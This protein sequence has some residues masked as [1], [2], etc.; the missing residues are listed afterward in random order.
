MIEVE[1]PG[2]KDALVA[3]ERANAQLG[4]NVKVK[5]A[6]RVAAVRGAGEPVTLQA[7][8]DDVVEL[9]MDGGAVLWIRADELKDQLGGAAARGADGKV[10]I[11]DPTI[12]LD[13]GT[14]GLGAWAIEG[15]QVLGI[16]LAGRTAREIAEAY[17]AKVVPQPGL[18][19]WNGSGL[20]AIEAKEAGGKPWLLFLHGTASNSQAGFGDLPNLQPGIWST[21]RASYGER[22]LAF[23]HRTLTLSPIANALDL[24]SALP[25]GA[26]LHLVSHSRGGLVGEL[27]GRGQ[28][29]DDAGQ[30]RPPFDETDLK[31]FAEE[32]FAGQRQELANLNEALAR[33]QIK[34]TRFVRVACPA[35][36]TS[37]TGGR[38][39][40]WL[41]LV[42]DVA[43]L[44][45]GGRLNPVTSELLDALRALVQAV[46]KERTDPTTL[47][48]LAA[49]SPEFSPLL[50]VLNRKDVRQ[51]DGLQ[52]IAGDIDPTEILHRLAVWFTDLYFGRD[53]DLVVD[54]GS[55]D[56]GAPRVKPPQLF[57]D[58]GAAVNHF[59]YFANPSSAQV[60]GK[61]LSSTVAK[62]ELGA[63]LSRAAQTAMPAL[64]SRGVGQ[65]PIVLV[66]PG[67][68]GSHL[69]IGQRRIWIDILQLA[70]GGIAR[71]GIGNAQIEPDEPVG[72]YYGELCRFLDAT[73]EVR[74]WAYDWRRSILEIATG[75]ARD[76]HQALDAT[77][78]PV[79]VIAHSMGGLV[80]RTAFAQDSSL[81]QRFKD[82][83]GSRLVMLGTPNGGS[84]SIPMLL[85]GRNRLMQYLGLLDLTA[86]S[87]DLLRVVV[88]WS[89]ALQMLPA[90]RAD[91]LEIAGWTELEQDDPGLG[92]TLP[93]AA[94]LAEV[95]QF[96]EVFD[97]APADPLRMFYI[98]GQA[99]TYDGIRVDKRA[100]AGQRIAFT[101]T[102][103]GDGQV[104]WKTGIPEGIR[105]WYTLAAHGDLARHEPAFAAIL[106]LLQRGTTDR[107]PTRLPV[108]ARS[109]G[110]PEAVTREVAPVVPSEEQL[111]AAAIGSSVVPTAAATR[112]EIAV[113]V[114]HGHLAFASHPVLVG[115]YLGDSLNGTEAVLD[116]RQYGRISARRKL[117][118]HPG[119]IE[120]FDVYL[121][122]RTDPKPHPPGSVIVGLGEISELTSG[123]LQR[124][125]RRGVLALAAAID[126][127]D[128]ALR[129][130]KG[131]A[132]AAPEPRGVSCI[133]IGTGEGVIAVS[134]C[135]MAIMRAV[136]QANRL[137]GKG[138]FEQLEII[139]VVEQQAINAWHAVNQRLERAEFKRRFALQ[140]ELRRTKGAERRIG[141]EADPSWWTPVTITSVRE[142]GGD[143]T[144]A[145]SQADSGTLKYV[146]IA[147][148][149]RAEASL[150]AT[151]R[152]FVDRYVSRMTRRR[153][154]AGPVSAPRTLFELLWPNRL[155]DQSLDDRNIRLILDESSAALPWEM[156][157]DRRPW[158]ADGDDDSE[159][160][161]T[162]GPPATRH[163]I[164]RQLIS[165]RFRE[166]LASPG[167]R[168]K[169]LVIGDPRGE[170]SPLQELPGAQREAEA[171]RQLLE[172]R[173]YKVTPLIGAKAKPEH[174]VSA[175]FADAWE[176]V[177]VAAHGVVKYVFP[178]EMLAATRA[179]ANDARTGIVLGGRMVLDAELL[180]QM[181][182]QPELFFVNCCLLGSIDPVAE[183]DH[184]RADRPALAS[185][186][187]VQLIKMGV[188]AVV[189][190][191]W[192]VNDE[193]AAR[194]AESFYG[195]LLNGGTLGEVARTA[196]AE[197]YGSYPSD[198]SWGAYQCYGQ[199][200]FRLPSVEGTSRGWKKELVFASPSEIEARIQG[201]EVLGEVGGERDRAEDLKSLRQL[202]E[203]VASYGW[204]GRA[205]LR[206]ALA[207]A[208]A[209][210]KEF[211]TAIEHY[212]AAALADYA[213]VPVRAIEQRLNLMVRRAASR[214][215]P[216]PQQPDPALDE[217]RHSTDA[218]GD[219]ITACGATLERW[220]LVGGSYK[221]LARR[222]KGNERTKALQQMEEAYHKARNLG[223]ERGAAEVYYPWSQEIAAQVIN[224]IRSGK[225]A[226]ADFAGLRR[227]LRPASS[228]DFWQLVL[229]ADLTLLELVANGALT[230]A[231][232]EAVVQAYLAAWNHT[233]TG[234]EMSS[235]VDQ[236]AFLI[237]MLDD[238]G[239]S[240]NAKRTKLLADL[241]GLRQQ[242]ELAVQA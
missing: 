147:G 189:A 130:A 227:S 230:A 217:I 27:L 219:L 129:A 207:S 134:D 182:V 119:P 53:H 196:R 117:G 192:E 190:A 60:L 156:M 198:S 181:P 126:E 151:R 59:N 159:V 193:A 206:S 28:L 162:R 9:Q 65:L 146:A 91:L 184:L 202:E 199:P 61:A 122:P 16:D 22:I 87:K 201:T 115:H 242:L 77:S 160:D 95:R 136:L 150:V 180:E 29:T 155:K 203:A 84:F 88:G 71:L 118:L 67:I 112:R 212:T 237:D 72:L 149:A 116:R 225:P 138:G 98:A 127:R 21:L 1:I 79:R 233:G 131:A 83:D 82:R 169:A 209:E 20:S 158:L 172:A 105:A 32:A 178:D 73:H 213:A 66:L 194:F 176:I 235:V 50:Q 214:P 124:T 2:H 210:L 10:V 157:D 148:R 12:P 7:E 80:A 153:V 34:V 103:E 133:L 121:D 17:E 23:E 221:R 145:P 76:L 179:T 166:S 85:L 39:D 104:L 3:G 26:E 141:P 74:P 64:S 223:Q 92:W 123:S 170:A 109:R 200:D 5:E 45:L 135:V 63:E 69:K 240:A 132:A 24:V 205:E 229:P 38:I 144:P 143:T 187:A 70:K 96:R 14:R 42:F 51:D 161:Q 111:L 90:S 41:N 241:N 18:R 97:K 33:K 185:G 8:A 222:T 139:E 81:W 168:Q 195:G 100:A 171:V 174:V 36:G 19:L 183:N 30:T 186:I 107:L 236:L 35:R 231:E 54:T 110:T 13:S 228:S 44:A 175:L 52:V 173:G 108:V 86:N 211:D 94:S 188:R 99:D 113:S 234:R 37:L 216:D 89:G 204:L 58:R 11:L 68:T 55:M 25:A 220:S 78:R 140:G 215:V 137:L 232:Q 114:V 93:T 142:D 125:I 101:V 177:H 163:G 6:V 48:G 165:R 238:P 224:G 49:M 208:Y 191:G 239:L 120:A 15:L 40:R 167:I 31:L 218:L 106:D 152:S 164:I 46:V 43:S 47:P 62:P 75:L 128:A 4:V 197:V 226:H 56:G 57:L 154:E 102:A